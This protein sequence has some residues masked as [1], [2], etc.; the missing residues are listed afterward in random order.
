M[1]DSWFDRLFY[2]FMGV[3]AAVLVGT[4][5]YV[6][7]RPAPTATIVGVMGEAHCCVV[8][9]KGYNHYNLRCEN[10]TVIVSATNFIDTRKGCE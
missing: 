7:T 2:A 1:T 9:P 5:T 4:V 3:C 10:N 8:E 6:V